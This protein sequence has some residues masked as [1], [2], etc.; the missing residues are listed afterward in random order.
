VEQEKKG[1]HSKV[2]ELFSKYGH[3]KWNAVKNRL[4]ILLLEVASLAC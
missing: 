4:W 3:E 1:I 2:K